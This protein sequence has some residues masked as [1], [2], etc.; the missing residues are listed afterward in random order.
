M[1][2]LH[3]Y[4]LRELLKT[5][6]LALAALTVLFTMGG[7]LYNIVRYEG[8]SAGDVFGFVP[9]LIPI[10][11]TL[12]MPMAALFATA[13][14]YGRLAADNELLACRA[15]GINIHRLLLAAV[16]LSV[17]VA[18]FSLLF[19]SFI[20]PSFMQRIDSFTRSNIRD[21]VAQ[22]LQQKGFV[23]RGREGEDRYTFTAE[24]VD[25]VSDAALRAKYFEVADGLHYLLV[26]NPT[27]LQ[28]NRNGD[29]VRFAA[30]RYVLCAFD[31]RVTP[32]EVTFHIRDGQDFEVGKRALTIT[33]QE[34]RI[35]VPTPTPFRLTTTD[36]RLLLRW[37]RAPWES[38]RLADELQRFLIDVT[39]ARFYEHCV[40]RLQ[41][42]EAVQLHDDYGQAYT[43]TAARA[44][45]GRDSLTLTR[46]RVAVRGADGQPR[47]AYEAH[48]IDVSTLPLPDPLVEL[49]LV[50]SPEQ[51]VL[52]YDLRP[53]QPAAARRKE[54][55]NLDRLH[56]PPEVVQ[57]AQ[58]VTAAAVLDPDVD[59]PL[60]QAL[61]DR[62]IGL[63][64]SAQQLLR[65]I[66]GTIN[67]RLSY[68][69]SALV[70]LLMG[71]ALGI[72]F[73]GSR[74]LAAFGLALIPF[75]VVL[76][77]LVLG[78]Q[79]TED[80]HISPIGPFVTWGGLVLMLL[81]DGMILRL[82]VRR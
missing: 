12:T 54:T 1:V 40:V 44:Q 72:I 28:L 70:T 4:V 51:D 35:T 23:H 53:G 78:R 64:K 63:Q 9:I 13:M 34:T 55:L 39:R 46:G 7:G 19:G 42:G 14:V 3:T 56:I 69:S 58:R 67:F 30:A 27:F 66:V 77:L 59:L 82:G 31:T 29:L 68:C 38:P 45:A 47:L 20:I 41:A 11:V 22:Q 5:F 2:T 32:L 8:V 17:F 48:R 71:A 37:R 61:G 73:R 16:L 10:V 52:E 24:K 75:F 43:L 79:L 74:A 25:Y 6:G 65:K 76:I 18:A 50:Q 60:D 15:A 26:T 21:L 57:D 36:L 81:A 62:R 49:R 80:P 33:D